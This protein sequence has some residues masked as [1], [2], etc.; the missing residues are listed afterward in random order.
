MKMQIQA[1]LMSL[2]IVSCYII[3]VNS[4]YQIIMKQI[5]VYSLKI[6]IVSLHFNIRAISNR[7]QCHLMLGIE[8]LI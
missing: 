6:K 5:T 2:L 7:L 4:D 8:Q 3:I 1:I